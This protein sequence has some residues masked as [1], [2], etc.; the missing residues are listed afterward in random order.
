[1]VFPVN[2][3]ITKLKHVN[4]ELVFGQSHTDYM[5]TVKGKHD[6]ALCMTGSIL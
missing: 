1:M 5:N 6:G 3:S 4:I 2:L